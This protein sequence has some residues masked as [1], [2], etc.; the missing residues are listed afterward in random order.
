MTT[1][2]VT[3]D[4]YSTSCS[5]ARILRKVGTQDRQGTCQELTYREIGMHR[6]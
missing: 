6:A 4:C 3:V 2:D 5:N 1:Q